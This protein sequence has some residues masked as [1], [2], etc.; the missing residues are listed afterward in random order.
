M[1]GVE[2]V[3]QALDRYVTERRGRGIEPNGVRRKTLAYLAGISDQKMSQ[4]LQQYRVAQSKDDGTRYVVAAQDYGRE[5]RWRILAKPGSDPK[6]VQEARQEQAKWITAD[7]VRR[8]TTDRIT[9]VE[10]ALRDKET[11]ERV[12]HAMAFMAEQLDSTVRFVKK[13]LTQVD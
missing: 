1:N 2:T 12:K 8:F 7:A 3:D 10:P 13:I 9:E 6:V 4:L 11:D 5:A